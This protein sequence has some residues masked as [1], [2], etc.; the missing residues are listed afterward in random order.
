MKWLQVTYARDVRG[1]LN[2]PERIEYLL[3]T[4]YNYVPESEGYGVKD[5]KT[6]A[7]RIL[8]G[9]NIS[10]DVHTY[11]VS[12]GALDGGTV[13]RKLG[14][15]PARVFKTLVTQ[16]KSRAYYVFVIPV[17]CELNLK[18]AAASV[19]E[20]SV[21][22]IPQKELLKTTGYIHGGCSPVGMKKLFRTVIDNSALGQERICVS[23][24]RVGF[25]V[26]IAP[27]DLIA[28]VNAQTADIA[29]H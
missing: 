15:D 19:G 28:A 11:D 24:G 20:K 18:A 3:P 25:Q 17:L 21:E 16:G 2:K 14:Q 9:L 12:D 6:N 26:D 22:M 4:W 13:A 10:F 8:E 27:G 1:M 23:A 7:M 5:N 29:A